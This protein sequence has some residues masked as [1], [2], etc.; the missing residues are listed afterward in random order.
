VSSEQPK[1]SPEQEA[2]IVAKIK[3]ETSGKV[4]QH[5]ATQRD[6]SPIGTKASQPGTERAARAKRKPKAIQGDN[7]TLN[8]GKPAAETQA[9]PNLLAWMNERH[10]VI[11]D[12]GGR[13]V[14]ADIAAQ[15][16][17]VRTFFTDDFRKRY[18][19]RTVGMGKKSVPL[20]DWFLTHPRREQYYELVLRPDT[21]AREVLVHGRRCLNLWRG[22][23][24]NPRRATG[25]A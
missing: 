1:R 24:A 22:F 16:D 14:V 13:C 18:Q 21:L 11:F 19:N 8:R 4:V 3:A 9:S 15:G 2:L 23:A 6:V 12:Y 7:V 17:T 25:A 20:G 5:P 10:A